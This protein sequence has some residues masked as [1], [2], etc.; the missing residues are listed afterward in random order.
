MKKSLLCVVLVLACV[1]VLAAEFDFR[2]PEIIPAP[3][4]MTYESSVPVRIESATQF[5]VA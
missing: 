4:E 1:T 3:K 2:R 5:T